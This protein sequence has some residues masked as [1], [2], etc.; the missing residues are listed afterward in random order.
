MKSAPKMGGKSAMKAPGMGKKSS[1]F[2][3][4]LGKKLGGMSKGMKGPCK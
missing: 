4:S 2:G 1:K 3:A